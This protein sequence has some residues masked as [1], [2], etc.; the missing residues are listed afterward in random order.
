MS[1]STPP[2]TNAAF[3]D[4]IFG[5][6]PYWATAFAKDPSWFSQSG[7]VA[8]DGPDFLDGNSYFSIGVPKDGAHG[9][10]RTETNC[11]AVAVLPL[12]DVDEAKY[13]NGTLARVIEVLGPPTYVRQTSRNS[14][15]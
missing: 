6:G 11:A 13:P 4:F 1:Y 5:N 14:R 7:R 2:A 12:D 10:S 15:Q 8:V 9:L 3:L